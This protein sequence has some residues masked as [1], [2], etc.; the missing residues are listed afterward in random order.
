M[1]RSSSCVFLIAVFLVFSSLISSIESRKMVVADLHE[2]PKKVPAMAD[3]GDRLF[4][5]ALPKG[6]VPA[7][8]PSKKGHADTVDEKLV[9]R[10]LAA[11]DHRIL[12]SVPSPGIGN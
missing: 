11:L 10:R 6:T 2:E 12:R 7:S 4:K 1:A 5:N 8:S 9:A 3:G